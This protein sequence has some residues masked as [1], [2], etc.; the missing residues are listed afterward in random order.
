MWVSRDFD[1]Q[2]EAN[3]LTDSKRKDRL[4]TKVNLGSVYTSGPEVIPCE[5][6]PKKSWLII[7][8]EVVKT[9]VDGEDVI[10]NVFACTDGHLKQTAL[11]KIWKQDEDEA[12]LIYREPLVILEKFGGNFQEN[13]VLE[14]YLHGTP[15]FS[16]KDSAW[17]QT[18]RSRCQ[19]LSSII[20]VD[21]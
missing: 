11:V 14:G 15:E 19:R 1:A 4:E 7:K 8:G 6:H 17:S 5:E 21:R 9:L 2:L 10:F 16:W 3:I 18:R 12:C 13:S 20:V